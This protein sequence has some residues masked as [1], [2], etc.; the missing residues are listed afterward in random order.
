[1]SVLDDA[2]DPRLATAAGGLLR[3]FN[4]IGLLAAADVHVATRLSRLGKDESETVALAAALAVRAPRL[5]HVFVDVATVRDTASVE[6]EEPV[7]LF[8]LPWPEPEA[9]L[10]AL[11][12]SDPYRALV[13]AQQR[14]G[15]LA[16]E[17]HVLGDPVLRL[18]G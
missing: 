5:G 1:M 10:R 15:R 13:I 9:W 17:D 4:E 2:F 18:A 16:V 14:R 6:S 12:D 8:A 7:D 3:P 11:G